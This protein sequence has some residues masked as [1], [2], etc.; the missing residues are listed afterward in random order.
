ME[1]I[2][3]LLP[4]ALVM[5]AFFLVAFIWAV[6]TGQMDDITTPAYRLLIE[7]NKSSND[8]KKKMNAPKL[9]K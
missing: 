3:I 7:D 2:W 1:V 5:A 9:K 4:L 6:R 8:S